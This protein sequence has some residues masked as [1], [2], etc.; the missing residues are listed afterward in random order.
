MA[1][2][3]S[4]FISYARRDSPFADR[5]A[6]ALERRGINVSYDRKIAVGQNWEEVLSDM[7]SQATFVTCV[8]TP[9]YFQS[10]WTKQEWQHALVRET[11]EKRVVLLPILC[12]PTDVP[13]ALRTKRYADLTDSA[14]FTRGVDELANTILQSAATEQ[15]RGAA[16]A[17]APAPSS[18]DLPEDLAQQIAAGNCALYAGA[19]LSAPAGL[20]VWQLS[21]STTS[22]SAT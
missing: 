21:S 15:L 1:S 22:V 17:I 6:E 7:L 19:G 9:G 2:T 10:E 3:P 11:Q 14:E 8:M 20:P 5:L 16:G 18:I 12:E 4:V 13:V